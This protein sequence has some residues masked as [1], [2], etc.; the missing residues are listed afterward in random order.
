MIAEKDTVTL[1]EEDAHDEIDLASPSIESSGVP[2]PQVFYH[3]DFCSHRQ[4]QPNG[5]VQ[6]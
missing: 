2:P 5:I 3:K 6:E 4:S 1:V